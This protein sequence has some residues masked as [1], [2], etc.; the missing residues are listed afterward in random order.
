MTTRR[1]DELPAEHAAPILELLEQVRAAAAA[2][3]GAEDAWAVAEAGQARIRTGHKAARRTLSAG[4][5]A[6]HALRLTAARDLARTADQAGHADHGAE[7][8]P[9]T[10]ALAQA[11]GPIGSWDWDERMQGALDLR[12]TFKDLPEPLPATVRPVRAIAA[13]LTHAGG[14]GLIAPTARLAALVLDEDPSAEILAASWYATHGVRLLAEL[15]REGGPARGAADADEARRRDVL[16][17]AVRGVHAARIMSKTDLAAAA[18]IT[19]RT[20]DA[21]TGPTRTGAR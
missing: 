19:R 7:A 21:W 11:A 10:R 6:A 14:A 1:L 16:R 13:W 2:P 8:E 5:C 4:Q 20:L 15:T 18:G 3:E 17:T 12:R 9:W